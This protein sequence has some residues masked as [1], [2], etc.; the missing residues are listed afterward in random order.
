MNKYWIEDDGHMDCFPLIDKCIEHMIVIPW[1]LFDK[2]WWDYD[3]YYEHMFTKLT[4]FCGCWVDEIHKLKLLK[5]Y[6]LR[7]WSLR[8]HSSV[9]FELIAWY[10][11][12]DWWIEHWTSI[13]NYWLT[14]KWKFV[15]DFVEKYIDLLNYQ[16]NDEKSDWS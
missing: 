11:D 8:D 7:E 4:P 13:Y 1:Q 16:K 15:L 5:K 2:K 10:M 3:Y 12:R 9:E 14:K 6:F